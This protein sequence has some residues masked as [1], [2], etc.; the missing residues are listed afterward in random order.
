VSSIAERHKQTSPFQAEIE[1]KNGDL[2][3]HKRHV[4]GEIEQEWRMGS[5]TLLFAGIIIAED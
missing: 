1:G 4:D 2:R 3:P 5:V